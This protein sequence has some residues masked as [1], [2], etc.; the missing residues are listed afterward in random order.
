MKYQRSKK[1][2]IAKY[3]WCIVALAGLWMFTPASAQDAATASSNASVP[4]LIRFSSVARGSD[5]K[6]FTGT[7]GITF[8]LY[9]EQ[10]GGAPLWMETQ[11]VQPDSS[12][13][14]SVQLGA[15]KPNGLPTEVFASGEARWVGTQISGQAEQPRV[16]LM[17]VPY[18]L[19]AGDAA[20]IGGLPPSA[21]VLAKPTNGSST[22]GPG[23]NTEAGTTSARAVSKPPLPPVTGQGTANYVPLW[24]GSGTSTTIG[25]SA[26]YQTSGGSVGIG[27][28]TPG[29]KLEVDQGSGSAIVGFTTDTNAAGV[30][31]KATRFST[32]AVGV[33]GSALITGIVGTAT[34]TRG[35]LNHYG[36]VGISN[37]LKGSG[38]FGKAPT[39]GVYGTATG[40]DG[41]GVYGSATGSTG[42]GI[43][44]ESFATNFGTNA[45]A[46]GVHGVSHSINGSGVAGANTAEGGTGL[47]AAGG[48][49]SSSNVTGGP[50]AV[51][52][53]GV[54]IGGTGGDGVDAHAGDGG[55][56]GGAGVIAFGG[57]GTGQNATGGN[58]IEATGGSARSGETPQ[59]GIGVVAHAGVGSFRGVAGDFYGDVNIVGN[60]SKSGGSFKIDHPLDPANQY[61]YHSFVESP[62]MMNIYN[63]NVIL[64]GKGEATIELPEWF[65]TLNRDF[66][67][68]LTPLG[69]PGP[70]LH[71]AQKVQNNSFKIGGGSPGL[72]VSWQVTGIRHDPWADA[73]RI[74]VQEVKPERERGF[75]LHPELYGAPAEKGI[76]W[77]R[78]PQMMKRIQEQR[79]HQ[80]PA[81]P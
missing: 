22:A 47:Y 58:G 12:G 70:N 65:E 62:D 53:G 34:D 60:L 45:G 14:Y 2:T 31:G 66:R 27:T 78:H 55:L 51:A 79:A 38:V 41:I 64:D 80:Q 24:T 69:N 35:F 28:T 54:E 68:Q 43:W 13:H 6:P 76:D 63:G 8:F 3:A 71:I 67:Y 32:S 29:A 52:Y 18:A 10:Q 1:H 37:G 15:T 30:S 40:A 36:V 50:G 81:K 9:K 59:G 57:A 19:K 25:N 56:K 23:T 46:D 11:N 48:G 7:I 17:S 20:T 61:L 33:S 39:T 42:Q 26:V 77:A 72:E 4:T 74:P 44:G 5:N 75:Y 21:F 16:L 49:G 73:H